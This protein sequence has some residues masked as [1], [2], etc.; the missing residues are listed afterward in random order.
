MEVRKAHIF[1]FIYFS[2]HEAHFHLPNVCRPKHNNRIIEVAV[3]I[4]L[5]LTWQK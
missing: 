1:I 2:R 5:F 3:I 4:I